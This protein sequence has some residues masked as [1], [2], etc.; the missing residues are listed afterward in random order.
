MDGGE[1]FGIARDDLEQIVIGPGHQVAF[2]NIGD[3][4][5]RR[6]KRIEDVIGLCREADLDKNGGGASNGTRVQ[7]GDGFVN[8]AGRLQSLQAPMTGGG[9]KIQLFRQ[10]RRSKSGVPLH[11]AQQTGVGIVDLML[12]AEISSF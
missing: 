11:Q 12:H 8:Y 5:D 10:L 9:G 4:R 2:Q 3:T 7:Q 1:I 6:L